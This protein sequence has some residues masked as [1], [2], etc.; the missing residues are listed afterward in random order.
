MKKSKFIENKKLVSIVVCIGCQVEEVHKMGARSEQEVIYS[1]EVSM[2]GH[3]IKK[4][5]YV[6]KLKRNVESGAKQH[7]S[8]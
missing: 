4:R 3:T 2:I 6:Q 8:F 1:K 5:G 7:N